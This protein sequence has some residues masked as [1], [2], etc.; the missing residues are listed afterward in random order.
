MGIDDLKADRIA[1]RVAQGFRNYLIAALV[2]GDGQ[3]ECEYDAETKDGVTTVKFKVVAT[4]DAP[5]FKSV[6]VKLE[7]RV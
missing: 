7:F 3:T 1:Q 6:D 4:M 5:V 2:E